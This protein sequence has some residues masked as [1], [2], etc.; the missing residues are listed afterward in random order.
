MSESPLSANVFWAGTDDGNLQVTRDGG[1]T[2]KNVADR[3]IG[4]PKGTYVSRVIA[5]SHAEG[6]AYATFDGHRSNDFG[7]YVY[8]TSDFGESWRKITTGLPDNGGVINVI[9]E[10][11]RNADLLFAGGE[12]GAFVTFNRGATWQRL[13]MNLPTVP[14]DDILVHPRDN[15]LILGTHGRSI[16]ILD[17]LAPLQEMNA[18]VL[19]SDVHVFPM[20][21]ATQWRPWPNTGSTGHKAFFGEN[22]PNGLLISYY[23]KDK[24]AGTDQA[25]I[26]ITDEAGTV[27]RE[28]SGPANAGVNR[29]TWD[30]RAESPIPPDPGGQRGP[31]GGGGFFG[32]RGGP[33]VDPGT[34]TVKVKVGEKEASRAAAVQEDPRIVLSAAD[35]KARRDALNQIM[36]KLAPAVQAQRTI[37]ALRASLVSEMDGWKKPGAAKVPENV[38]AA[39]DALLKKID[40]LYPNFGTPPSEQRGLGD[41]GPPLVDRPA[42]VQQRMMQLYGQL[43]NYSAAP[44]TTQLE[45]IRVLSSRSDELAAA[46]RSLVETDLTALNKTMNEAGIAHIPTPASGGR[47]GR[48]Q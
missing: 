29:A 13:T 7:I 39:A 36:P 38:T 5:S 14:V 17:D 9:R 33:P 11:P 32:M 44:T 37:T 34:F 18:Q 4:V 35:R 45:Q 3:A 28:L 41:A 20:R 6:T 48:P 25:K 12:Y 1:K 27:V 8:A 2:W 42:P 16:W 30:T 47:T 43:A 10:D 31:G 19:A 24:P 46:V 21:P 40:E 23:L 22:P 26:I 15:D